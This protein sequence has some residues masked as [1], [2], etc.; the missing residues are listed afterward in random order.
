MPGDTGG[1][2][3]IQRALQPLRTQQR[4]AAEATVRFETAPGEQAQVDF[5]EMQLWLGEAPTT[6][7]LFVVTLGYS[8]RT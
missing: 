3:Q 6:V 2:L 4:W 8:R 7:H 1:Y 5:G